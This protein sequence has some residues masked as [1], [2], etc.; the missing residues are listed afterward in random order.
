MTNP[1]HIIIVYPSR[2]RKE[3][4][5]QA[6]DACVNNIQDKNNYTILVKLDTDDEIMTQPEVVAK[7]LSYNNIDIAWGVSVSKVHAINRHIPKSGWDIIVVLS[8]DQFFLIYGW[9]TLV[10][11]EMGNSFPDGDGYLHFME[12][13]SMHHLCVQTICDKKYYNRFGYIYNPEYHSLFCDNEGFLVAKQLERYKYIPYELIVHKNPA[14]SEYGVEK[15]TMFL[16]QQE[17]G[18]TLDQQTFIRRQALNFDL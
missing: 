14:Y 6:L 18:Y 13:D 4:F 17:I 1:A 16:A 5:F 8:D 2:G 3:R 7:V 15:D 11:T 12:K 10:R 9:D